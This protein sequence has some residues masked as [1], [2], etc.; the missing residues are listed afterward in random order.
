MYSAAR[1]LVVV[2][3]FFPGMFELENLPSLLFPDISLQNL[4]LC[5][6]VSPAGSCM[7]IW[8]VTWILNVSA[9]NRAD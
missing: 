7:S 9:D 5:S 4:A 1:N 3:N 6:Y 8:Y 2:F